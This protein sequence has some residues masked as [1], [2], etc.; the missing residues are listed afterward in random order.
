MASIQLPTVQSISLP[1]EEKSK[2][3]DSAFDPNKVFITPEG[4][5]FKVTK[6]RKN[7]YQI[8]PYIQNTTPESAT[9]ATIQ[10][11]NRTETIPVRRTLLN[12]YKVT[13]SPALVLA[14]DN[15]NEESE[16]SEESEIA[17][18][19]TNLLPELH[20]SP[21]QQT[22]LTPAS[23]EITVDSSPQEEIKERN[24][25]EKITLSKLTL[26]VEQK[27]VDEWLYY[28][29]EKG[30]ISKILKEFPVQ[31]ELTPPEGKMSILFT[32]LQKGYLQLVKRMIERNCD[33]LQTIPMADIATIRPT[34]DALRTGKVFIMYAAPPPETLFFWQ[35]GKIETINLFAEGMVNQA[36]SRNEIDMLDDFG[37]TPLRVMCRYN[38]PELVEKL[39]KKGADDSIKS[40][41]GKTPLDV[42]KEHHFNLVV[43]VFEKHY[44]EKNAV[45]KEKQ[46][47][48]PPPRAR[49]GSDISEGWFDED[50]KVINT[51]RPKTEGAP[52]DL[53]K[54]EWDWV[55]ENEVKQDQT[56]SE[57]KSPATSE[58]LKSD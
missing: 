36:I 10:T 46:N 57:T 8:V 14:K 37:S 56:T 12:S 25:I 29:L 26:I 30:E 44:Q 42:A 6:N 52:S 9:N 23:N 20:A 21:T 3:E 7:I 33:C 31:I 13:L 39:L 58:A 47:P 38:Q 53:N 5:Q 28:L 49:K 22:D 45:T 2:S 54:S 43:E 15:E 35:Q 18:T 55:D 34:L 17:Q 24:K 27:N 16:E 11:R 41:D 40:K 4:E 51:S 48:S 1:N 50:D 19:C 32:S